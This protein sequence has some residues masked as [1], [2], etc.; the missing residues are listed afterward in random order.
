MAS[1]GEVAAFGADIHE[2]YWA[3]V[4]FSLCRF[5]P[6][7]L[8]ELVYRSLISTTGFKIPQSH[9]GVLIGGDINTPQ[10]AT[11]ARG[12][13]DLGFRLY[14]SSPV[15]EEFLNEMPYMRKVER[16]FFPLVFSCITFPTA[17]V[18]SVC[19]QPQGQEKAP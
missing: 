8:L 12:L 18:H 14:C 15:V 6:L 1:T 4:I 19:I 2:A 10:L 5:V 9:S 17:L 13:S 11:V 7:T 3:Y 16:I